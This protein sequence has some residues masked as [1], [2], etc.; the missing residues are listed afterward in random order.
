MNIQRLNQ[1]SQEEE[2]PIEI[3]S[4]LEDLANEFQYLKTSKSMLDESTSTSFSPLL[5]PP[6]T[7]SSPSKQRS[8]ALNGNRRNPDIEFATEIGQGLLIEVRKLQT[9]IQ[10]K[11]D[12]IKHLEFSKADNER[13]YESIQRQLKQREE[14]EERLKEE[15]WN[16]EVANQEL[17][18]HLSESN[19]SVSKHNADYARLNKQLKTQSEQI[20]IMKAQE[21]KSVSVIEAMKARHEQETH[22]LRRHAASAQRDNTQSQKQVE[23]LNTELKIVKAKLAIKLATSSRVM[24]DEGN[25]LDN[26]TEVNEELDSENEKSTTPPL[27]LPGRSQ[28]VMETETLKQSLAHAHRII[29][30][31]RSSY[32]KE[33]LEKFEIKKML[34]DSQENIEQL[35]KDM[36]SWNSNHT[37]PQ[38]NGGTRTKANGKKKPAKKR[39]GG[40]ARQPRGLCPNESDTDPQKQDDD[41]DEEVDTEEYDSMDD[42]NLDQNFTNFGHSFDSM[43]DFNNGTSFSSIPMKPLSSELE[44]KVQVIDAGINTDPVD[45]L[46]P[47]VQNSSPSSP[48][49]P[50]ALLVSSVAVSKQNG[51]TCSDSFVAQQNNQEMSLKHGNTQALLHQQVS[52]DTHHNKQLDPSDRSVSPTKNDTVSPILDQVYIQ[53]QVAN[54]VVKE[55]KEIAQRAGSILSPEQIETLFLAPIDNIETVPQH[56]VQ[57]MI[58]AAVDKEIATMVPKIQVEKLIMEA[59]ASEQEKIESMDLIP[60]ADV[61][62]LIEEAVASEQE[63]VLALN[64]IPQVQ[65]DKLIKEAVESEKVS[66]NLIP[67]VQVDKLIEEAVASEQEKVESLNL[68]PKVE[69]D[70]LIEEAVVSEKEKI[71]S[72]N[73]MPKIEVEKLI[74]EAVELE[75][76]KITSLNLIPRIEAEKMIVE[77]REQV[78][79]QMKLETEVL[80]QETREELNAQFK[81]NEKE[82]LRDMVPKAEAEAMSLA[83][84]ILASEKV[85]H[86]VQETSLRNVGPSVSEEMITKKEAEELV[87]LATT[88]EQAKVQQALERQK[89]DIE[90]ATLK[91]HMKELERQRL[92]M[93]TLKQAELEKHLSE[94]EI[95]KH[96]EFEKQKAEIEA[97]QQAELEEQKAEIE[98]LKQAEL[99]KQRAEIEALK[100]AELE[101][102]KAEIEALKQTELENQKAEIEAIKQVELEKQKI[103]IE[104]TIQAELEKQKQEIEAT[105]EAELEK[106]RLEIEAIK[107]AELEKQK[108][109]IEAVDIKYRKQIADLEAV[110]QAELESLKN[111][112]AAVKLAELAVLTK[113]I[114]TYKKD[115]EETNH[116]MM[117]M[118]TKDSVDVLVK[119]AVSDA[120][121]KSDKTQSEAMAGMM[122]KEYAHVMV[123]DE[124]AKALDLERKAVA[125]REENEGMEMISKAEAEALAKVAAADAIVKERQA[126]AARENELITKEEAEILAAAAAREAVDKERSES[127]LVLARERKLLREKEERL[128]SQ[129][130]ADQKAKEAVRIALLEN[131]NIPE[132]TTTTHLNIASGGATISTPTASAGSSRFVNDIENSCVEKELPATLERSVST[133]RLA[134]PSLNISPAPSVSTPA[135]SSRKLRLSNSVSS[136]R[137]GSGRK[138]KSIQ[139]GQ[140]PSTD[141][142]TPSNLSFGSFRILEN[143][144]YGS[145]LHSKSSISLRELSNKQESVASISTM[146]SDEHHNHGRTPMPMSSEESFPG[147]SN[148]GTD[149]YIISSIT[150]TMIGEWMSKHTRRYVGGGISENKHLRFFWVHPYTKIL[151]WSSVQPGA[152]GNEGKTKSAFVESVS[153]VP[154][155]DATGASPMSLLI[156][157]RKRDLKLTAPS[158]ERHDLWLKSL[159]YLLGRPNEASNQLIEDPRLTSDSSVI[160]NAGHQQ[161]TLSSR[162]SN[163]SIPHV[164]D[165]SNYDSDDSDDLV[166]IRQCCDGK[167]DLSTLSK[168]SHHHHHHS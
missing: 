34:S 49:S 41:D 87:Q 155:H 31:L 103:E 139:K 132:L 151:Y 2:L 142:T 80:V 163:R 26:T 25:Q 17:R 44:A 158:L 60:K 107:E 57:Q 112:S 133:S 115:T 125:E 74:Q 131:K 8:K 81:S 141:S 30:N 39:R 113:S 164:Q 61:D 97:T 135:S 148:S 116:R 96:A 137:L 65:V 45:F 118:L 24:S 167:H 3:Q 126:M 36:T 40:V 136:L 1:Y 91:L 120:L 14:F 78:T 37:V 166:N 11:D 154:S 42:D 9:A 6:P 101:E 53:E 23:E 22:V 76:E 86:E 63:K 19:Q 66:L 33:K 68:I 54:A 146:S 149:M 127:A 51:N 70:K 144:K 69:V 140:R 18:S 157:T 47:F 153:A 35:R 27:V 124:V 38:G 29:S 56:Q 13:T 121:E 100:Q 138:E 105:K 77:T 85:K 111:E 59:V 55:R 21:E 15:N 150:Q 128:V 108:Q 162:A 147:F 92:E 165:V 88:N 82:L 168:G 93:F 32:H 95:A 67:M 46:V 52:I 7:N 99:E 4:K 12:I 62:K 16:L 84:V 10:E 119:R 106:Q 48:V 90:A 143:S 72:L 102:Q 43:M 28:Q 130:E 64:L 152:E 20:D 58:E 145:K 161:S 109:E 160:E 110:K 156:R 122:S 129:E 75:Q 73:L 117:T 50:S 94:L 5:P 104:A 83:A 114:E 79:Q 98:T 134:P 71:E 89:A 123:K 159:S